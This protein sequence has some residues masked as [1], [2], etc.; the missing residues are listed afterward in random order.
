MATTTP[1]EREVMEM[2]VA[3]RHN[4]EIASDLAI[5]P[6]TV[7]IHKSRIMQK[8]GVGSVAKLVR[9]SIEGSAAQP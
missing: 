3:G 1:R 4:R 5:S 2:V 7:E 6:R 8:L 9:L